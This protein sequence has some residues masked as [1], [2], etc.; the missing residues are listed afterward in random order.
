MGLHKEFISSGRLDNMLSSISATHALLE[1]CQEPLEDDSINMVFCFDHE[2]IGSVSDQGA[3]GTIVIDSTERIYA[4]FN[5][6]A[7][8]MGYKQTLRKSMCI[9]ADMAHGVHPNYSEKHQPLHSPKLHEGIVVKINVNQRYMTD[10]V[11]LAIL[12]EIAENHGVPLQDFIIKQDLP[13]G[14]TIGP[15]IAS[16]V[17]VKTIDV[18]VPQL[19]MH[20]CREFCGTTDALYY[21]NLFVG[22]F[23]DFTTVSQSLT[24][25]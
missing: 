1:V 25:H 15:H 20:S 21:K 22:F 10:S 9:S 3:H 4:A 8:D 17:G 6:N 11:T 16:T 24:D 2:E 12:R 7:L 14:S 23:K 19:G 13:C 18:G 5:D